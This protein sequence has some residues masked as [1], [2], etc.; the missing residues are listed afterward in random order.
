MATQVRTR[1]DFIIGSIAAGA[2][3]LGCKK[4]PVT[5]D[6]DAELDPF[7]LEARRRAGYV[8]HTA[9]ETRNCRACQ[10]WVRSSS[11][12]CGSCKLLRGPI[13]PEGTCRLFVTS[14]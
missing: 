4:Q 11:A 6:D 1:R 2:W 7:E 8:E 10:Y 5:C 13:H 3:M 12:G 14:G 9:N